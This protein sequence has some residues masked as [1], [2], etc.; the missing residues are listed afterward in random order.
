VDTDV[1]KAASQQSA[2]GSQVRLGVWG[3]RR[4]EATTR[5]RG[6]MGKLLP[7]EVRGAVSLRHRRNSRRRCV[8]LGFGDRPGLLS[9]A[10]QQPAGGLR[11]FPYKRGAC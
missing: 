7:K 5:T 1:T 4:A 8:P 9:R 3:F 2:A 6:G 10:E 11:F